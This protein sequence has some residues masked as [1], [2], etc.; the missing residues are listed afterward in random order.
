M[1]ILAYIIIGIIV[2]ILT[3]FISINF[4]QAI[5]AGPGDIGIVVSAIAVLCSIVVIC[6]IVIVEEIK[7]INVKD[8]EE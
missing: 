2:F 6:T 8:E 1:T 7:S 4:A 5:G 3:N